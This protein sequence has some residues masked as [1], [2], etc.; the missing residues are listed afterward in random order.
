MKIDA[1]IAPRSLQEVPRLTQAAEALGFDTL[2]TSETQHDPFLPLAL[3]AANSQRLQFGTAIAVALGRSPGALAYTAWDLASASRGRFILGLGSQVRAHIER[4]FGMPW[5]D[6][7]LKQLYEFI[8]ALRA[9][10]A[11]WQ[12]GE[13]LNYRGERYK[14]TLMTPF[15]DPGPIERPEIPIYLAAVNYGMSRL[16][17]EVAD[18]VHAHPLHTAEYLRQVV[19]AGINDGAQRAKRKPEAIALSVTAF[20]VT[21]EASD[22]FVRSQIAFYASTPNYRPVFELHG[23]GEAADE[24]S[25][26]ARRQAWGE[27]PRQ[28]SDEMLETLAVVG[29]M[30]QLGERLRQRYT[31]LVDRLTLYLPFQAGEHEAFWEHVVADLR[32]EA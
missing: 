32:S 7:P 11:A 2:W 8:E 27:M 19:R 28:I 20:V 17:G 30:E 29:P 25:T 21:D 9:I 15:F 5:P 23:W 16:A 13:R 31:G 22:R 24:L 1:S 14:L 26:L 10:W 4:R 3:V 6:D 18:G 12:S